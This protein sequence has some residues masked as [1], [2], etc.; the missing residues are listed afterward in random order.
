MN[1]IDILGT[2][3]FDDYGA[4]CDEIIARGY[5]LS[6]YYDTKNAWGNFDRVLALVAF[7]RGAK[8]YDEYITIFNSI[9]QARD[10]AVSNQLFSLLTG[11]QSKSKTQTQ[12]TREY[13]Q[14]LTDELI[15][16]R[17]FKKAHE[18][19]KVL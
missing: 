18:H 19:C 10:H 15:E 3:F 17:A 7:I 4:Y 1:T 6:I 11:I 13:R 8:S 16:L 14:R 5:E 2:A 9:R 12:R